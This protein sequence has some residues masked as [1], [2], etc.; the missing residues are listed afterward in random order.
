MEVKNVKIGELKF[1]EYNPRVATKKETSELKKSLERFGFVEPVVVNSA[2]K[3][4]NIII[5][6]HF[7]VKVA[8]DIGLKEVPV[9]YVK[10]S[11]LKKEK[12]LNLRLNKNLGHWDYDL[13]A[14]FDEEMLEN[15]G[16]DSSE[17]DKIL[18][19]FVA[20]RGSLQ[21][22]FGAPPF[23]V[24]DTRQ[25][26]WQERKREW[27]KLL[28]DEGESREEVLFKQQGGVVGKRIQSIGKVSLFDPVLT[29]LIY[30][31]FNIKNGSILDVFAGGNVR[32]LVAGI[33]GYHYDG[34]DLREEQVDI[35]NKQKEKVKKYLNTE[36][37]WHT[38]DSQNL[39]KLL[40]KNKQYDLLFTCPPYHD[41]E[42]YSD[43]PRDLSNM[44]YEQFSKVYTDILKK[45]AARLKDNRFAVIVVGDIRDNKGFYRDFTGLTKRAYEEAGLKLYNDMVLI[46]VVGSASLRAALTMKNRKVVKTH[47][48]VLVFYKGNKAVIDNFNASKEAISLHENILVFYK[49]SP[50]E[51][52]KHYPE[53]KIHLDLSDVLNAD[54]E[55]DKT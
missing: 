16:F 26:Y 39:E 13:L 30:K 11:D 22:D 17:L 1:A 9:H 14:G 45:S 48:N 25:G 6:G 36:P 12:E 2:P 24:L 52:Q 32:G 5:G 44:D 53:M 20:E 3:R 10:I 35:N 27:K 19:N 33:L 37:K 49:G 41:L 38:G 4:K 18:K 8:K 29:E 54:L 47:Q 46:N 42:H 31:W 51:I 40:P 7:R 23:S 50:K 15:V 34:I 43:D 28:Q 55:E 21:E